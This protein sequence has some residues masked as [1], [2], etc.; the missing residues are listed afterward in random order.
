MW[1]H[2][3]V[4]GCVEILPYLLMALC[5]VHL[6]LIDHQ[7]GFSFYFYNTSQMLYT[8]WIIILFVI[9]QIAQVLKLIFFVFGSAAIFHVIAVLF[10]A[11][12]TEYDFFL[13]FCLFFCFFFNCDVCMKDGLEH[14]VPVSPK[15]EMAAGKKILMVFY[16]LHNCSLT[17]IIK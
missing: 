13:F 4:W 16:E 3:E 15:Q 9:L 1:M 11:S 8:M 6:L 12:I 2:N 10:G 7:D 5:D 17:I 14:Q